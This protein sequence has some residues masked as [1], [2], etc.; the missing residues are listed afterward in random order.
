MK[1]ENIYINFIKSSLPTMFSVMKKNSLITLPNIFIVYKNDEIYD[2]KLILELF[3]YTLE[4]KYNIKSLSRDKCISIILDFSILDNPDSIESDMNIF[5]KLLDKNIINNWTKFLYKFIF[6]IS[7]KI[8][9]YKFNKLNN[10]PKKYFY[11]IFKCESSDD[12]KE[13]CF[14][15]Y[16]FIISI[17]D[18][19]IVKEYK[20]KYKLSDKDKEKL[21]LIISNLEDYISLSFEFLSYKDDCESFKYGNEYKSILSNIKTYEIGLIE[22]NKFCYSGLYKIENFNKN[23]FIILEFYNNLVFKFIPA[24][25]CYKPNIELDIIYS[26]NNEFYINIKS[27]ENKNIIDQLKIFFN[28]TME[29][30]IKEF[31]DKLKYEMNDS[32]EFIY[33]NFKSNKYIDDN[34]QT[35][36][37]YIDSYSKEDVSS[38]YY[39]IISNISEPISYNLHYTNDG[40]YEEFFSKNKDI[41]NPKK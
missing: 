7:R 19:K 27:Y 36:K 32:T 3:K 14:N 2:S 40:E 28:Y 12:I 23:D 39:K 31:P 22:D 34:H 25:L 41:F 18:E 20:D 35:L 21:D 4:N 9:K 37:E 11:D 30:Q 5:S 6:K 33:Q 38:L 26:T 8:K 24:F 10:S 29:E 1:K 17:I 13:V 15:I 16:K